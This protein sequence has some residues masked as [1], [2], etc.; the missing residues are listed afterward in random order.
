MDTIKDK[1]TF[2]KKI[3]VRVFAGVMSL[4]LVAGTGYVIKKA[5]DNDNNNGKIISI[6]KHTNDESISNER[7][8][9]KASGK[10]YYELVNLTNSSTQGNQMSNIG[11]FL[12][13]Y[14]MVFANE[15]KEKGIKP[16]LSWNETI[17]LALA[18]SKDNTNIK[19]TFNGTK[20]NTVDLINNYKSAVNQLTDAFIIE[21]KKVNISLDTLTDSEELKN[22]YNEVNNLFLK[23]KNSDKDDL[24]KNVSELYKGFYKH[25]YAYNDGVKYLLIEPIV[26]ASNKLFK[27]V[28]IS[29]DFDGIK[30]Y[31][32]GLDYKNYRNSKFRDIV[33]YSSDEVNEY[34]VLYEQFKDAE[35]NQ[36]K[37]Y[38][39]YNI[40]KR[41]IKYLNTYN[42]S[43]NNI[44][45]KTYKY[46]KK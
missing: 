37:G 36:L 41:N 30:K 26:K 44:K 29:N 39:D 31:Y 21:N 16:S 45:H 14:N 9:S 5:I 25:I 24:K 10:D 17:S 23:A 11:R 43:I 7:V 12:T 4:A 6:N 18:Y 13:V 35:I 34:N 38:K 2:L 19:E 28:K 32:N 3:K 8:V 42:K 46:T 33:I 22:A 20:L 40:K 27:D 1:L 15:H